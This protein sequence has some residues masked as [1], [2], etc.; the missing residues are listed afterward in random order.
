MVC[1]HTWHGLQLL[2]Y[3]LLSELPYIKP[4]AANDVPGLLRSLMPHHNI[5]VVG[6][7]GT[8]IGQRPWMEF[9]L[10]GDEVGSKPVS[11][12][13]VSGTNVDRVVDYLENIRM[14]TEPLV[15][16]IINTLLPLTRTWPRETTALVIGSQHRMMAALGVRDHQWH[17][18]EFLGR[19]RELAKSG[20]EVVL[21]GHSLGGGIA[22][23]VGAL[24]GQT[25]I[26]IQPP[27]VYHSLAKHQAIQQGQHEM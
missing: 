12:V 11:I 9:E 18:D 10:T 5:S 15:L 26:A 3:A 2:D 17:Y 22:L 21:T 6:T 19:V 14:W 8:G 7:N 25:T 23:V 16:M 24:T 13:A 4:T 1:G 27:G 20:R